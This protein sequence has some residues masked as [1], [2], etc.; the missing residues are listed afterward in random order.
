[1]RKFCVLILSLVFVIAPL[2][3]VDL[4]SDGFGKTVD[5]ARLDALENLCIYIF[6]TNVVTETVVTATAASTSSDSFGTY[7]PRST[8]VSFGNLVGVE[9]S[10][11]KK[12]NKGY[13]VTATI[14]DSCY[15][16]YE[17]RLNESIK[18]IKSMYGQELTSIEAKKTRFLNILS[19]LTEYSNCRQVLFRMLHDTPIPE[20]DL[21]ITFQSVSI[22]YQSLLIEEANELNRSMESGEYYTSEVVKLLEENHAKQVEL[23]AKNNEALVQAEMQRIANINDQISA[24]LGDGVV[25]KPLSINT[26][27][28]SVLMDELRSSIDNYN[29]ICGQYDSLLSKEK[30]KIDKAYEANRNALVNKSYKIAELQD[31]KPT[32]VALQFRQSELDEL[33]RK[34]NEDTSETEKLITDGFKGSIQSAYDRYETLVKK[35]QDTTFEVFLSDGDFV[36]KKKAYKGE[37]CY[38]PFALS[39][40][41]YSFLNIPELRIYYKDMTGKTP[42]TNSSDK[43][44]YEEYTLMVEKLDDYFKDISKYYDMKVNFT[45]AVDP[46]E[47]RV[48]ICYSS[49]E[50]YQGNKCVVSLSNQV[51]FME[52]KWVDAGFAFPKTNYSFLKVDA[53]LDKKA[54]EQK[55]AERIQIEA[56]TRKA[57]REEEKKKYRSLNRMILGG[58]QKQY[59]IQLF[60]EVGIGL[61][62]SSSDTTVSIGANFDY[63]LGDSFFIGLSPTYMMTKLSI[64]SEDEQ[65]IVV[66]RFS[67][68]VEGGVLLYGV[69]AVG[70][71]FAASFD[72]IYLEVFSRVSCK[73]FDLPFNLEV[74]VAFDNMT[75]TSRLFF[76]GQYVINI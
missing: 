31:G 56:E 14:P 4:S 25:Y 74:G 58:G 61:N 11:E 30:E 54:R 33:E 64:G 19:A 2:F 62:K 45:A 37:E 12:V 28:F 21:N 71:R 72:S 60:A 53:D 27:S 17:K 73:T 8:G 23:A 55:E 51:S 40:S 63:I 16:I 44:K 76:G 50:L 3:S 48:L 70:G 43:G 24:I 69:A 5:E 1:M 7:S 39:S 36:L 52:K 68:S 6:G 32:S 66:N 10:E 38:W 67:V 75:S 20:L 29:N 15:S 13:S 59:G 9:Y 49:V 26:S 41:K 57:K 18:T 46:S 22:E 65:I 42:V 35:F 47:G 34:Y